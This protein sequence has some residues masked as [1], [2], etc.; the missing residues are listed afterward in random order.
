MD[1]DAPI[2]FRIFAEHPEGV[3]AFIVQ[4]GNTYEEGLETYSRCKSL[5]TRTQ[6]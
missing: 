5:C 1:Y 4:N 6:P 3:Q 2:G